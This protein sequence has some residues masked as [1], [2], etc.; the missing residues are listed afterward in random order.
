MSLGIEE[1][2]SP[3]QI[4]KLE[5]AWHRATK[6]KWPRSVEV[7]WQWYDDNGPLPKEA[8][9]EFLWLSGLVQMLT[10]SARFDK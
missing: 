5:Q 3:L 6:H 8:F 4:Q 10:A 2:C 7:W 9:Q 1:V